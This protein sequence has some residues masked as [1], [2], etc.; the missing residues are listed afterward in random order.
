MRNYSHTMVP[1]IFNNHAQAFCS[2][3]LPGILLLPAYVYSYYICTILLKLN[4]LLTRS[5]TNIFP[6]NHYCFSTKITIYRHNFSIRLKVTLYCMYPV[7][8]LLF[9]PLFLSTNH[10]HSIFLFLHFPIIM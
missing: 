9:D 10:Y 5:N 8:V 3:M 2:L 1:F 7:T 4:Y 6:I